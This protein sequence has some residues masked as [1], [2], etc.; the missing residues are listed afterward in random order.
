MLSLFQSQQ[1]NHQETAKHAAARAW[2]SCQEL[3]VERKK[4]GRKGAGAGRCRCG[5]VESSKS[6]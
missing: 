5:H 1:P 4:K 3:A 6:N 2:K